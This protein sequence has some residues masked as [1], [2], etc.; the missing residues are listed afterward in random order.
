MVT[1][2][3]NLYIYDNFKMGIAPHASDPNMLGLAFTEQDFGEDSPMNP[4]HVFQLT[5]DAFRQLTQLKSGLVVAG[6]QDMPKE[7]HNGN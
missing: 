7:K 3:G 5:Q 2:Q 1:R 6:V 4:T